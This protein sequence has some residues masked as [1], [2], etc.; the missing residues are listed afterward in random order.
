M[1]VGFVVETISSLKVIGPMLTAALPAGITPIVLMPQWR[2]GKPY[3]TITRKL[4]LATFPHLRGEDALLY[5]SGK[6][7]DTVQDA[8]VGIVC[9]LNPYRNFAREV[10]AM[11]QRGVAVYGLD[12]FANS[13][14]VAA[15]HDDPK[16][17]RRSLSS[18]TGRVVASEYW[19]DL[20]FLVAPRHRRW[21]DK[22]SCLGT[23]LIDV[24]S[25]IDRDEARFRMKLTKGR[26]IVSLFTPNIRSPEAY[27]FY[28]AATMY[29]LWRLARMV[30]QYCSDR[31]YY[32]VVKSREKQWEAKPFAAVADQILQDIS[33]QVHP[34]TSALLLSCSI[35]ALHFGS[36]MPLE[37][38]AAGVPSIAFS[39][40]SID[41]LHR[42][43]RPWARRIVLDRVLTPHPGSLFQYENVSRSL[44]ISVPAREFAAV[45]DSM[46]D[47]LPDAA[48]TYNAFN[49]FFSGRDENSTVTERIF[50][51]LKR[52]SATSR[53]QRAAELSAP[54]KIGAS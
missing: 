23:P 2:K 40:G 43:M 14:Y 6:L 19:R 7:P 3:D 46:L 10:F 41:K 42:Y 33:G 36:M 29:K 21:E 39:P 31:G 5:E 25:D 1:K 12:Y 8:G 52:S 44:P 22:F 54:A 17:I 38:A 11:A 15:S 4:L 30:R 45:A 32:L 28:G 16:L 18:L 49:N 20:E 48:G 50:A 47:S 13:V 26:P 51:Q 27:W 35:M 37:A 34:S 53:R 9:L 24:F